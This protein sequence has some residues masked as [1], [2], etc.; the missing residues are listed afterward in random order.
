ME[1]SFVDGRST[2]TSVTSHHPVSAP[3][4][5]HDSSTDQRDDDI[6]EEGE[7]LTAIRHPWKGR[8]AAVIDAP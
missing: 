7:K 6:D 3:F 8:L 4:T 1:R 5:T 2:A